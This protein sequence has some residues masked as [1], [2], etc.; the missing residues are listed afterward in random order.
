MILSCS[1]L[2]NLSQMHGCTCCSACRSHFV[3]RRSSILS[4]RQMD[5]QL[6]INTVLLHASNEAFLLIVLAASQQDVHIKISANV[7]ILLGQNKKD[8]GSLIITRNKS[9][10][11]AYVNTV[12][13]KICLKV[14]V[15]LREWEKHT[16]AF[17]FFVLNQ[18]RRNRS[19]YLTFSVWF[20]LF[21]VCCLDFLWC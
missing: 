20:A 11:I 21:L 19:D 14:Y 13:G 4:N 17:C 12:Y 9:G 7:F 18:V 15:S 2:C 8:K 6:N 3:Q 10:Q 5:W 1:V 16:F